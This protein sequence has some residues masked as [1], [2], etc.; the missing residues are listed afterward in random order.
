MLGWYR[1]LAEMGAVARQDSLSEREYLCT[2]PS[3]SGVTLGLGTCRSELVADVFIG[4]LF[5]VGCGRIGVV[6]T[7][8]SGAFVVAGVQA[9]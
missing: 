8:D 5:L 6:N 3:R 9:H 4:I 7:D 1:R 2:G